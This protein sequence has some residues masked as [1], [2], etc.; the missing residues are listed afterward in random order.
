MDLQIVAFYFFAHEVLKA[1]H[2]SD[3]PQVKMTNAEVVTV[4]L[5]SAKFF[6]GNQRRAALF[7]KEYNYI[8]N[9]LSESHFNR[10][11]HRI[12]QAIWLR[13][14][15]VLAEYFK[16]RHSSN[17]YVVDSFPIPVCENVRIFRAKIFWG[18]N[19]VVM[20]PV[21]NSSSMGYERTS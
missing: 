16:R 12:P 7:L 6:S 9:L 19:I 17:E 3:N 11:L 20:R 1:S 14:F 4:V 15:S 13:L 2:L 21:K 10:R 5:T 8:P 18:N